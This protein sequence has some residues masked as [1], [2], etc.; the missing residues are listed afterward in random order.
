MNTYT[1]TIQTK[2]EPNPGSK[3]HWKALLSNPGNKNQ[4]KIIDVQKHDSET[5]RK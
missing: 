4:Y 5:A 1:L 2:I 3:N